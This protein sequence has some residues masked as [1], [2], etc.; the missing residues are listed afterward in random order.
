MRYKEFNESTQTASQVLKALGFDAPTFPE[1]PTLPDAPKFGSND[2]S[3]SD[4]ADNS[5][6]T[7]TDFNG[8]V[9]VVGDSIAVGIKDANDA[10]GIAVGG[11]DSKVVLEMVQRL[12]K[13]NNVKGALVILS[14]G[15]SNSTYD[16][17][18][19]E[20]RAFD[21]D[22]VRQQLEAL[23]AAGAIVA[24]VGTGSGK[25]KTFTNKYGTYFVNFDKQGVNDKLAAAAQATGAKFLGPLENYDSGLNSGK[26]DGIHPYGGYKSIYLAALKAAGPRSTD[27]AKSKVSKASNVPAN[28]NSI[29]SYLSSKGLDSN[30]VAGI[31]ANIKHE[32]NFN[33]AAIGDNGQSGGLFQ[34]HKERFTAMRNAA[35]SNWKTN[36]KGQIDFALSEP[37]GRKYAGMTFRSAEEATKWWTMY[38]EIPANATKQAA[39]RSQSA[40]QFA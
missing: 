22:P 7:S 6:E 26:G 20:G 38:F 12:I 33:P 34:H 23:K 40:S 18:T 29:K 31:M 28:A 16:R 5:S 25:S 37:A 3:S 11:K 10:H 21:I 39:I 14:S 19:G 4:S 13:E 8:K 32:S 9:Y 24:L 27:K 15:A 2:D 17:P 36:W 1:L 35:G 30:K